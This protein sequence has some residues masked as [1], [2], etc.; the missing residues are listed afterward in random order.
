VRV[1]QAALLGAC[2]LAPFPCATAPDPDRRREDRPEEALLGI[3]ERFDEDGDADACRATSRDRIERD[4]QSRA[5]APAWLWLRAEG[6]EGGDE[7]AGS[8]AL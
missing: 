1:I 2:L 7:P 5:A 6:L 4:P 3:A 8:N